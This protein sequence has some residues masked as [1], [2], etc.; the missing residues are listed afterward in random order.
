MTTVS[1]AFWNN[2][3]STLLSLGTLLATLW[4]LHK[5]EHVRKATNSMKD[6][7]VKAT[8]EIEHAKGVIE[9]KKERDE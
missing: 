6:D 5:I 9:G 1:D 2:L 8:G 4:G 7:L 3:P